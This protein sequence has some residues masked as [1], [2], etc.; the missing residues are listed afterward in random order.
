MPPKGNASSAPRAPGSISIMKAIV[1]HR[2]GPPEV[3]SYEDVPEPA[4]R[5]GEIRIRIHAATVNR[6]LDVGLRAGKP[7]QPGIT[8]PLIPG[9][10]CAGVIEALGAGVTRWR[11][12]D[13][14]AVAGMMP[15]DVCTQDEADYH[16]PIGMMGIRRPGGFAEQVALPACAAVAGPAGLGFHHAALIMRHA[17]TPWNPLCNV[18]RLKA[19]QTG[20][21]LGAGCK[22]WTV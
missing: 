6:V 10:D 22:L 21:G 8:L 2:F 5:A 11:A 18:A 17:P 14:V 1:I 7:V 20:L 9:V 12:G 15:L 16:G 13:R 4:P 3:M 19:G